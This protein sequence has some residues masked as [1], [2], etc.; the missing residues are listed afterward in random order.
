MWYLNKNMKY[1]KFLKYSKSILSISIFIKKITKRIHSTT[2][3]G[4]RE[5][6]L[7]CIHNTQN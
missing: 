2:N 3:K 1:L 4:R 6:I 7:L 5:S